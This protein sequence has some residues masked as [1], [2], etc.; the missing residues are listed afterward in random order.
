MKIFLETAILSLALTRRQRV[1]IDSSGRCWASGDHIFGPK[2]WTIN[3]RVS[4]QGRVVSFSVER[5]LDERVLE[6]RC[7]AKLWYLLFCSKTSSWTRNNLRNWTSFTNVLPKANGWQR[8]SSSQHFGFAQFQRH[9]SDPK[10]SIWQNLLT[11][12]RVS[13]FFWFDLIVY[14][15]AVHSLS[16]V[17]NQTRDGWVGSANASSVLCRPPSKLLDQWF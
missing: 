12:V 10:A 14:L 13:F 2:R 3:P 15:F 9:P 11:I 8:D 7:F 6:K 4:Q 1:S 5:Q 17:K 16:G